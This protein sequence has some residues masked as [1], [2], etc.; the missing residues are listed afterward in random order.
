MRLL[1]LGLACIGVI[2]SVSS[3]G[4]DWTHESTKLVS[5]ADAAQ[6]YGG[7]DCGPGLQT[8][9][10]GCSDPGCTAHGTIYNNDPDTTSNFDTKGVDCTKSPGGPTCGGY[11]SLTKNNCN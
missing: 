7:S 4:F 9:G 5:D 1:S 6:L 8:V 3:F 2:L 11:T 10:P